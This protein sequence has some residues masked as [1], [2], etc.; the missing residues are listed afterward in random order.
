MT[1]KELYGGQDQNATASA[2]IKE[3][4]SHPS[5]YAG[6]YECIDVMEEIFGKEAVADFC[7]CNSFKHLWRCKQKHETPL[8]DLKK[9]RFYIDWIINKEEA[10]K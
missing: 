1:Y 2:A 9:A 8:T 5:H 10:H 6:K 4:V 3:E 7:L